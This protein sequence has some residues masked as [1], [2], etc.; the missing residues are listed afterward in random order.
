MTKQ[1]ESFSFDVPLES[2]EQWMM[3]VTS[4]KVY[5]AVYNITNSN[6]KPKILLT[7]EQLIEHGVDIVLVK[8]IKF[9]KGICI[10]ENQKA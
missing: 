7:D 3:G 10:L 9:L 5:N 1:K 8:N 6:K 2:N 4:L